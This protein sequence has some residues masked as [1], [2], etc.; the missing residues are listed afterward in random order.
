M[1][2]LLD[3]WM[4]GL[5]DG[6]MTGLL[7]GWMTDILNGWMTCWLVATDP[8]QQLVAHGQTP[9]RINHC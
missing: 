5:L 3:G 6:W 8:V 1:T 2:G 7:D 9:G 4:T